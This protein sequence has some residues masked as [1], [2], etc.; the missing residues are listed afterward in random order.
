MWGIGGTARVLI[1]Y[2]KKFRNKGLLLEPV[3][4]KKDLYGFVY[5]RNGIAVASIIFSR[6]SMVCARAPLVL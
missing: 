5:A 2:T 3:K 1:E 6:T 4:I